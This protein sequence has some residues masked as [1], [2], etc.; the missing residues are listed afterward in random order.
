MQESLDAASS[1]AP[2][3]MYLDD[4]SFL[5]QCGQFAELSARPI[6]YRLPGKAGCP[7][8]V[9]NRLMAMW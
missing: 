9:F 8:T 5:V 6:G 2:L 7:D 4:R 3:N 1:A